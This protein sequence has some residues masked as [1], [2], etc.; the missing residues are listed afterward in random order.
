[1]CG[2]VIKVFVFIFANK[3]LYLLPFIFNDV[4][5]SSKSGTPLLNRVLNRDQHSLRSFSFDQLQQPSVDSLGP[6]SNVR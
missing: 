5:S 1:M 2:V 3:R 4:N 6:L